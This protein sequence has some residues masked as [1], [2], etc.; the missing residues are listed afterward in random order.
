MKKLR[1]WDRIMS[2]EM[3]RDILFLIMERQIVSCPQI[4]KLLQRMGYYGRR[5]ESSPSKPPLSI[6]GI[7]WHIKELEKVGLVQRINFPAAGIGES[8]SFAK[9]N[10]GKKGM[11][12]GKQGFTSLIGFKLT[13]EG[14][15]YLSSFD[16]EVLKS[17]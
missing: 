10:I 9:W 3:K 13:A 4:R 7:Y 2:M 16:Y 11:S 6:Q 5:I 12:S 8:P 17:G 14:K 15:N 1:L